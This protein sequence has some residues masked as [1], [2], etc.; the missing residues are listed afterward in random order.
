MPLSSKER[1]AL[2]A[3]AHRLTATVH[4]GHHGV[5]DAVRQSL[6]DD[7]RTHELVKIQF[8]K[9]ADVTIKDAANQLAQ[10]IGAEVVQVIGRTA[11]IFRENPELKGRDL[12]PWR[13]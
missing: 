4:V 5:T 3:E 7:L 11:T 9:T 10:A 12:P 1:A 13:R 2:R 8:T 6:D